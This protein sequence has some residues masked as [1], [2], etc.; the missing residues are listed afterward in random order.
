MPGTNSTVESSQVNIYSSIF[1]INNSPDLYIYGDNNVIDPAE[2]N[3][4]YALFENGPDGIIHGAGNTLADAY[5]VPGNFNMRWHA[6][7]ENGNKVPA[8]YY[9]VSVLLEGEN[10][11]SVKVRKF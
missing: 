10:V 9:I 7:D 2:I 3:F 5:T 1:Y 6:D 4:Q 8:G 11:G